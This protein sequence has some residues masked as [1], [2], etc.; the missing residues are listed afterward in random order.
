[1]NE[2]CNLAGA[3]RWDTAKAAREWQNMKS[4]FKRV[5]RNYEFPKIDQWLKDGR[6]KEEHAEEIERLTAL[7]KKDVRVVMCCGQ[8]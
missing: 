5:V 3:E 6:T 8:N 7:R 1:V 4:T 2:R